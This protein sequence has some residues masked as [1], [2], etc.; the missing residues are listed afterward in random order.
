MAR[1]RSF[2]GQFPTR[3]DVAAGDVVDMVREVAT[4]GERLDAYLEHSGIGRRPSIGVV[5]QA[6]VDASAAGIAFSRNPLTGL[7]EVV[8]EAVP[9]RGQ[10]LAD[11]GVTPERWVRRWGEF[12]IDAA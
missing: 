8:V 1:T 4:G 2:A 7:A 11:D 3:L 9:G 12:T 10:A 6:M 5:V